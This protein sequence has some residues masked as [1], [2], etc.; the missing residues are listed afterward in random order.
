MGTAT[1]GWTSIVATIIFFGG[2][3]CFLLGVYGEYFLRNLFR[4]NLLT[5][6]IQGTSRA[7]RKPQ[8]S[9]EGSKTENCE[10]C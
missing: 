6:V 1:P 7:A 3:Q 8:E 5:F 4:S 9:D 2:V 10:G